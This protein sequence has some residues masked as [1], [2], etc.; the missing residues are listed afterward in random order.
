[1]G[2]SIHYRWGVDRTED[3]PTEEFIGQDVDQVG[4]YHCISCCVRRA[5]LCGV[6]E[7][8]STQRKFL[9]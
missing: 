9:R 4:V 7:A 6:D 3:I 5:F 2:I 1:M 8:I